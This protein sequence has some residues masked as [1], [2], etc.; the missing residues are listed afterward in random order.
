MPENPAPAPR[1]T[2][3]PQAT[4]FVSSFCIMVLELV[5]GRV[6]SRY[7]GSSLYTWTS[8]IGVVLAGIAVGNWLGGLIADRRRA[9]PT[10]S[11][12]FLASA[13]ACVL[14]SVLGHSV[15]EWVFL[16]TLPWPMRVGTHVALIF[17]LPSLLLGMISPV[18]AKTA[19]DR[20][21][22]TGRTIGGVYAWGV[23]G[24]LVGTFFTGFWLIAWFG[25]GPVVWGVGAVLAAVGVAYA[26]GSRAAWIAAGVFLLLALPGAGPWAWAAQLGE[27]LQLRES[28]GDDLLYVDESQYSHIRIH[29]VSRVPDLRNMHLDKLVH[30]TIE[31]YRPNELHYGYERIYRAITETFA[32]GRDSLHTLTVGGGGYVFPRYLESHYPR[33]STEVVEIDPAVT[34]AAIEAF[35]L[36]ADN[37]LEIVHG[38][39]RAFLR[40]RLEAQRSAAAAS[41]YDIVYLDAV[42]DYSVP[43]QLAAVECVEQIHELLAPDGIFLMNMIDIFSEGRFLGAMVA[44]IRS[45]FPH[46][47]VL[48]EG[49][50]VEANPD[51][52]FTF[53]IAASKRPLDWG[54]IVGSY[55]PDIRLTRL[56]GPEL[57]GLVARRGGRILTD[58]WAPVENLLAPVVKSAWR[59]IASSVFAK[60]AAEALAAGDP[61]RAVTQAEKALHLHPRNIDASHALGDAYLKLEKPGLAIPHYRRVLETH[62]L[63]ERTRN[64]LGVALLQSGDRA[65]AIEEFES[66]VK[67]D[68]DN[69]I[70]RRNLRLLRR[71]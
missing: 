29:Q 18:A 54:R 34:R 30:S 33:G 28:F 59:E 52:R 17:L 20:S 25:T 16:W 19:I 50:G 38:D 27:R 51:F 26:V 40:R 61:G 7:L 36:P 45:V 9:G 31:M 12:L 60:R 37:G 65:G 58:D 2:W 14:I 1:V 68:P 55:D 43:Y 46:V 22:E 4:V 71:E 8:V 66:I 47:E 69:E 57:E 41:R 24:S 3:L 49:S 63:D 48:V 6:V 67:H 39:G 53:I 11:V 5:A 64:S 21:T 70:A 10:L 62:P 42:N 56:S 44:T 13:A 15:G 32:A 23:V 35:G